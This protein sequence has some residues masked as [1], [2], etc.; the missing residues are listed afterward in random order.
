MAINNIKLF[1]SQ[2]GIKATWIAKQLDCHPTEISNWINGRRKPNL[3]KAMQLANL[4]E[5]SVEELFPKS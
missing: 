3:N 4:L 1:L 5:C 2:K